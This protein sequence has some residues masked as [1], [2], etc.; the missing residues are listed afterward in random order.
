M[1][2]MNERKLRGNS[3][4]LISILELLFKQLQQTEISRYNCAQIMEIWANEK[5]RQK[6]AVCSPPLCLHLQVLLQLYATIW[7]PRLHFLHLFLLQ[8][9]IIGHTFLTMKD[10]TS[11]T[12]SSQFFH[13]LLMLRC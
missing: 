1:A 12:L 11:R 10:F 9:W 6:A 13:A 2:Q 3:S 4:E 8:C 5:R 7:Q